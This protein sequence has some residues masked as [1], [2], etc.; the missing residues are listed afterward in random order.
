MEYCYLGR[1]TL[2]VIKPSSIFSKL[3]KPKHIQ[4]DHSSYPLMKIK[5]KIIIQAAQL[6]SF[7]KLGESLQV[8]KLKGNSGPND[9]S[10]EH[11][12]PKQTINVENGQINNEEKQINVEQQKK[13][14]KAEYA[15]CETEL[16]SSGLKLATS[17]LKLAT[18]G[19][20]EDSSQFQE[21][22]KIPSVKDLMNIS[23]KTFNNHVKV[24]SLLAQALF[25]CDQCESKFQRENLLE[26][27]KGARH[28]DQPPSPPKKTRKRRSDSRPVPTR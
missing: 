2:Q 28:G 23:S 13:T 14:I 22:N 25:K 11:R 17:G 10:A 21:N 8:C 6:G 19:L 15:I 26:I 24:E 5:S 3:L 4:A 18:S 16:P 20:K 7:L 9:E 1:V 27:H 12:Q